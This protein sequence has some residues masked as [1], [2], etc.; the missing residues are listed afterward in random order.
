MVS[1]ARAV[2]DGVSRHL[3][4]VVVLLALA[5]GAGVMVADAVPAW[6]QPSGQPTIDYTVNYTVQPGDTLW[7]IAQRVAPRKQDVPAMVQR[8]SELNALPDST[9]QSGQHLK[10]PDLSA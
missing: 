8:I 4:I 6:S 10:L 3:G 5:L 1:V 7:S 9:L 2:R